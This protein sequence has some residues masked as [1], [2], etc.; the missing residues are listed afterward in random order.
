MP[1][2]RGRTP[3]TWRVVLSVRGQQ[4]EEIVRGSNA[5]A[6]AREAELRLLSPSVSEQ[7]AG[8]TVEQWC[9][10][11]YLDSIRPR[12]RASTW[13]VR[14]Q[15]LKHLLPHLR[16]WQPQHW[17]P[18]SA[19]APSAARY[20]QSMSYKRPLAAVCSG[21]SARPTRAQ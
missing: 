6:K 2:Y 20:S 10:G 21:R 1:V 18:G 14:A 19:Q 8:L 17:P 16:P 3:G 5:E 12:V 7:R 4:Q 9:L 15:A 11:R 13:T